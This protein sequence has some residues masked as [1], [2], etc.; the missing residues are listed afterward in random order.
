MDTDL[1][2]PFRGSDA[3]RRGGVTWGLLTGPGFLR[4]GHDVYVAAGTADTDLSRVRALLA[5]GGPDAVATGW[6]AC[7]ALG[8]D[9]ASRTHPIEINAVGHRLAPVAG[10]TVWRQRLPPD[11]VTVH[12]GVPTTTALRTAFD[13]ACRSGPVASAVDRVIDPLMDAVVAADALA[14]VG[15][16]TGP[17]LAEFAARHRGARGVRRV[18]RVAALLDPG[19]DSPPETRARLRI[20][21]AGLPRP[22]LQFPVGR[23]LLDLAWPAFR[24]ALEYDGRDH[25]LC[26]RRGRDLDRLEDLRGD[27]WIVL[28]ATGVQ[29]TRPPWAPRKVR[30]ALEGR[31]WRPGRNEWE[32]LLAE[33]ARAS[34]TAAPRGAAS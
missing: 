23:Y 19:S 4:L 6:S 34:R 5:R 18:A 29:L 10:T 15:G 12:D 20:V 3:V 21:F 11:E 2:H 1:E 27:G 25:A 9:V 31:G 7:S 30:E 26:D 16:F 17:D 24:V 33:N 13:L 14:R 28:V 8:L 22:V 32:H